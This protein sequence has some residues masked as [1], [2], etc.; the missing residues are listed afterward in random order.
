[1]NWAYTKVVAKEKVRDSGKYSFTKKNI[2]TYLNRDETSY[3]KK[4]MNSRDKM[5]NNE[6]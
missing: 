1:M 6:K 4:K 3:W 5:G 2:I